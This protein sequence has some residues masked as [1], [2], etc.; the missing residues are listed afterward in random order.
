MKPLS[1][2]IAALTM[3]AIPI[4]IPSQISD[5]HLNFSAQVSQRVQGLIPNYCELHQYNRWIV[6]QHPDNWVIEFN[7]NIWSFELCDHTPVESSEYPLWKIKAEL[8]PCYMINGKAICNIS[9]PWPSI[10]CLTYDP[11]SRNFYGNPNSCEVEIEKGRKKIL[12]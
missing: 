7:P 6:S 4:T 5:A 2:T 3:S 1:Q 12:K 11:V 8:W 9:G 10:A